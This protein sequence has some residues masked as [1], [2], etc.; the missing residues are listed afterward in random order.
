MN[1]FKHGAF[2][3]GFMLCDRCSSNVSCERFTPKGQCAIEREAFE[4]VVL[5]LTEEFD[6]ENI[7]DK[8]LV[9]RAAMYLIRIMRAETYEAGIGVTFRSAV[10]GTYIGRLDNMLRRLFNDL[11]ISRAKRKQLEKGEALLV[12]LDE[13]M[14]KFAKSTELKSSADLK[15]G[16]VNRRAVRDHRRMLLMKWRRDY[17][18]LKS[19]LRRRRYSA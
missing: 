5:E 10:W 7:A 9:D 15:V 3:T 6:L 14:R 16:V 17:P 8:I 1:N 13:V 2:R 18:R 19:T 11:A 12:S 4:K